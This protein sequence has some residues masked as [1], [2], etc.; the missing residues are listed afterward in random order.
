MLSKIP[1][2]KLQL[3][4]KGKANQLTMLFTARLYLD[5]VKAVKAKA[6]LQTKGVK[7]ARKTYIIAYISL[8]LAFRKHGKT[9]LSTSCRLK[10][11]QYQLKRKAQRERNAK[12]KRFNFLGRKGVSLAGSTIVKKNLCRLKLTNSF[13]AA[14]KQLKPKARAAS[15]KLH[16]L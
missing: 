16:I 15:C 14:C 2:R 5:K 13:V 11:M 8:Q 1:S 9:Q 10:A 4:S 12:D 3:S 7:A 6:P